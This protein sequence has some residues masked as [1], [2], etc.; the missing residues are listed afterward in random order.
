ML[1]SNFKKVITTDDSSKQIETE[2]ALPNIEY[3][4][5][6]AENGG[7][8]D[9]SVDLITVAQAAHWFNLPAFYAEAK[10]IAKPSAVL[11]V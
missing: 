3:C 6:T 5:A 2:E 4:V 10:R 8:A 1:G 7:L 11:A 9:K